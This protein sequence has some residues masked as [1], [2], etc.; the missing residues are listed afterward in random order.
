M[1][2]VKKIKKAASGAAVCGP[3][4]DQ[5]K[6]SSKRGGGFSRGSGRS[7]RT[8]GYKPPRRVRQDKPDPE[9]ETPTKSKPVYPGKKTGIWHGEWDW[10][11]SIPKDLKSGYSYR[12]KINESPKLK[13]GGK[14]VAKKA[15]VGAKI[16]SIKKSAK[17]KK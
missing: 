3:G 7:A 4:D 6:W 2:K 12:N 16:K 13:K 9:P 1:A 15:R 8:E 11:K 10:D 17:K 14:A 5:C